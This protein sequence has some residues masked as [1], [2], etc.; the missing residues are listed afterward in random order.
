M[1]K[2]VYIEQPEGYYEKMEDGT[3][4][5]CKLNKS[6]YGKNWYARLKKFL[7]EENFSKSKSDY[8]LYD[9]K[10]PGKTIYVSV[11]VDDF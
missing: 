5:E 3:K 4:L 10:E 2:E 7:V 8:G 9:R 11:W 1:Q 6:I